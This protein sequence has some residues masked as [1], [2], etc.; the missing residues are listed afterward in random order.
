MGGRSYLCARSATFCPLRVACW[1]S[2]KCPIGGP[3]FKKIG[4]TYLREDHRTPSR[5][6]D[7]E[8]TDSALNRCNGEL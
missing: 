8:G 1:F 3:Y 4:D 6:F 2:E 5:D 7:R